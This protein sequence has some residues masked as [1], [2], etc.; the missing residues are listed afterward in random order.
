MCLNPI[1]FG[2]EK[3]LKIFQ[4]KSGYISWPWTGLKNERWHYLYRLHVS[5]LDRLC[6]TFI[7]NRN[8]CH[9]FLTMESNMLNII[10]D[11][12]PFQIL[13]RCPF[14]GDWKW[15]VLGTSSKFNHYK[16]VQNDLVSWSY[17]LEDKW[18][19]PRDKFQGLEVSFGSH[20]GP[21]TTKV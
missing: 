17:R 8:F 9:P 3:D 2:Q 10:H 5:H 7:F 16:C 4:L 12:W 1:Q 20:I 19:V 13:K 14:F 21:I 18:S 6:C 15:W 11:C